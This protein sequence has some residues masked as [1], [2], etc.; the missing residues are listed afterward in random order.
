MSAPIERARSTKGSG[1]SDC[2]GIPLPS[3][4]SS[5]TPPANGDASKSHTFLGRAHATGTQSIARLFSPAT[6]ALP[7]QGGFVGTPGIFLGL[8]PFADL[9]FRYI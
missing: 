6:F 3:Q 9:S 4:T 1:Q 5:F 7:L 2:A 8:E